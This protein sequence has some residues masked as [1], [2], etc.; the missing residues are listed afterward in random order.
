[1]SDSGGALTLRRARIS[2][3]I[4]DWANSA[5]PTVIITFVFAAYFTKAVANDPVSA[6]GDWGATMAISA[7]A[8]AIAGPILG[9]VADL[10]GRRK[11][12]LMAFTYICAIATGLLWF[13]EP[14]S[15]WALYALL[16]VGLANF[17]F[18]MGVVFYNSMLPSLAPKKIMGRISGWAWGLGYAGG[19]SCLALALVAFVQTD[20]PW[21]GILKSDALNIRATTLLVSVWLV[22][23]SLPLFLFTPDK[24]SSGI[25]FG[26]AVRRGIGTLYQTLKNIKQHGAVGKYLL[27][28][29]IYTDGINTLFAFGGI[30]AVGTFGMDFSELIMF[31]IAIN[32]TAGI[33]AAVFGWVD[34]LIGPKK[35]VLI[36]IGGLCILGS[37]LLFIESK[38][39]FWVFAVPLGIFVGPA[40]AASRTYMANLV[41][42]KMEAE[43]FGLYALSGKAT[44]FMGPALLGWLSVT[45]DSQRAGM[46]SI[47]VFLV[48]G[49]LLLLP[50]PDPTRTQGKG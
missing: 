26:I 39:M 4:Y 11:P 18:E 44:A 2:W 17:A 28:R 38:T 10:G 3:A 40:Q 45:F 49:A 48:V 31:G 36:A 46:A 19:L 24:P 14:D 22:L 43:M 20:T 8:V 16:L 6:T 21:F 13:V 9:A 1:M 42:E 5:F 33:G 47:I 37:A 23:F 30:Y 12:W 15:S 34:D 32:V 25:G 41:P 50:L 29:M 27:A 7:L 35:T